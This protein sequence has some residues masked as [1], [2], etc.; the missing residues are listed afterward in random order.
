MGVGSQRALQAAQ[1]EFPLPRA[2]PTLL[3]ALYLKQ[4]TGSTLPPTPAILT[5]QCSLSMANAA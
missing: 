1:S 4:T 3:L 5:E 2:L